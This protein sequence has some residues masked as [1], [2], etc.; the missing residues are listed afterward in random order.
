[1]SKASTRDSYGKA[2]ID[3]GKENKDVVVLDADLSGSTRTECFA[4][5][6]PERFF[7]CGVAEQNMIT[8]AAGLAACGKVVFAS[9]FAVFATE[10]AFNQIKQSIA[11]TGLNVKIVVSHSGITVGEDGASH[12]MPFDIAIMR[13]LPNMTVI[14]PS[15]AI[16]AYAAVKTVAKYV[17]PVYMRLSRPATPLVFEEGYNY[18]GKK[19][20]F[21]IGKGVPLKNGRDATILATG[22]MVSE[23]LEAAAKLELEEI[24]VGVI[25]IHTIKPLDKEMVLKSASRTGAIITAEDHSIIGGLGG[26]VAEV[27]VSERPVPVEMVGVRDVFTLSGSPKELMLKYGL[28][29]ENIVDATKRAIKRK[30]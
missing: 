26:A 25:N 8:M 6:F 22:I 2:L 19:L 27:I 10:R 18:K 4:K 30:N 15:D 11:Y 14:S 28:T 16:E 5:A 1:M 21:E 3:L 23:A 9:S 12:H 24:D 17:G 29:A 13:V 7:D 20:T